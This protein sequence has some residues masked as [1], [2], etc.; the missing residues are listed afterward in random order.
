MRNLEG[1]DQAKTKN[2]HYGI[3]LGRSHNHGSLLALSP[4][5]RLGVYEVIAQIGEGGPASARVTQ[6]QRELRRGLAEARET[7][8]K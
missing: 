5:T 3:A 7:G 2:T 8:C 1:D 6:N 4:G